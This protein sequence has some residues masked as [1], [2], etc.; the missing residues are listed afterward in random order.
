MIPRN[1]L[2][3]RSGPDEA[4]FAT[5]FVAGLARVAAK[6]GKGALADRMGRTTRSLDNILGG[7]STSGKAMFDALL[8]DETALDEV[9]ASY[10]FRLCPL[11]SEAAND[12]TVAAGVIDAMGELVRS[13]S[14]GHRDHNETL[15]VATLLRPHLP[16]M[17]AIVREADELR[18]AA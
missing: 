12:L 17:Q 4:T 1:V 2:P 3:K 14:D 5:L 9:L 18:G 16:A 8:A 6:L 15:A 10:G 11:H 13:R 7:G